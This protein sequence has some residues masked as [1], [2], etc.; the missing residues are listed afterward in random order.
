MGAEWCRQHL[1]CTKLR[2]SGKRFKAERQPWEMSRVK[3]RHVR[4][5]QSWKTC[6]FQGYFV[7]LC[8]SLWH[9]RS[10]L[11]G[12]VSDDRS[13]PYWLPETQGRCYRKRHVLCH[14]VAMDVHEQL[15]APDSTCFTE[16]NVCWRWRHVLCCI[17]FVP[18]LGRSGAEVRYYSVATRNEG[19]IG[20]SCQCH[21][22]FT[23]STTAWF[24]EQTNGGKSK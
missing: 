1:T 4:E 8:R 18:V 2:H 6:G 10:P 17:C 16:L 14:V 11:T 3:T 24:T 12:R 20:K 7:D 21:A 13:A 19:S 15:V 22:C 5:C 9:S 23:E